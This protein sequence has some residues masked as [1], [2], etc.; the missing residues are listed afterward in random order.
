M[1]TCVNGSE[2]ELLGPVKRTSV[3]DPVATGPV[4]TRRENDEQTNDIARRSRHR[5]SG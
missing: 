5:P 3:Y 2:R 4:L 1:V